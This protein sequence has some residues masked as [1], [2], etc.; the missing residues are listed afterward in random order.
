MTKEERIKK[1]LGDILVG[2]GV[3][4]TVRASASEE[5]QREYKATLTLPAISS[6]DLDH[7]RRDVL[8]ALYEDHLTEL[9]VDLSPMTACADDVVASCYT[10]R[11]E[12]QAAFENQ[13]DD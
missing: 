10:I 1:K 11:D 2:Y 12:I 5:A 6:D 9:G 7:I 3:F 4:G 13:D 8:V